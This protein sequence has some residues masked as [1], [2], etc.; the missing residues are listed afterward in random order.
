MT[1]YAKDFS[2]ELTTGVFASDF[3]SRYASTSD[4]TIES[5]TDAEDDRVFQSDGTG[6]NRQLCSWDD[7]DGD[8]N[9]DN[10]EMLV[11]FRQGTDNTSAMWLLG[12]ASGS[13][14]SETCYAMALR[15]TGHWSLYRYDS[16]TFNTGGTT[17][18]ADN[19][20]TPAY[21]FTADKDPNYIHQPVDLFTYARFRVNGTGA[22]VT[23]QGRVWIDGVDGL[24][25]PDFWQIEWAD[26]HANRIT[27]AGWIGVGRSTHSSIV[28]DIDYFSVGTNGDAAPLNASTNT[29]VRMS[30][31]WAEVMGYEANPNVR[32]S[33]H[34]AQ[35]MGQVTSPEARVTDMGV[36]V[37]HDRELSVTTD[38][39]GQL[40]ITT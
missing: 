2:D 29:V 21:F 26:T 27:S 23:L 35:V 19:Q 4:W 33:Q 16:G 32:M 3:T 28:T 9:R 38:V 22:T 6:A 10:C 14:S 40:I 7:V 25:E 31:I 17:M 5:A 12:R 20:Y 8:A 11:R 30:T 1:Q 18:N 36:Q 37:L 39:S 15:S 24:Q 34:F 13:A